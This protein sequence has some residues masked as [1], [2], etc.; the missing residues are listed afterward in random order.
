MLLAFTYWALTASAALSAV[1]WAPPHRPGPWSKPEAV[2][3]TDPYAGNE[4]DFGKVFSDPKVKAVI[5]K[6]AEGTKVD[7]AVYVRAAEA[8]HRNIPFGVYLLGMSS[9]PWKG[10]DGVMRAGQD[11]IAQA[12]LLVKIAHDTHANLLAIDIEGMGGRFMSP[13]DAA[14]AAARIEQRSAPRRYPLFYSNKSTVRSYAELYGSDSVFAR[15]PLWLAGL[16]GYTP[17]RI[18]RDYALL[19]FGA[20][21]DCDAFLGQFPVGEQKKHANQDNCGRYSRYPI[22]GSRYDLDVNLVNGGPDG[23][24]ALFGPAQQ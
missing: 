14:A 11:T 19:Q 12:D 24:K 4:F 1:V 7:S 13:A 16:P 23:L 9:K 5:L 8:R 15:M 17:N 21:W 18:W 3:V 10:R 22:A 2:I 6:A 20:E